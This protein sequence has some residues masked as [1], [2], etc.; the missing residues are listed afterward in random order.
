M[1]RPH[2][3]RFPASALPHIL[4]TLAI[5]LTIALSQTQTQA[6]ERLD[7]PSRPLT[8]SIH[9]WPDQQERDG[10]TCMEA[11]EM[12]EVAY[13]AY[14]EV[15]HQL[16][17]LRMAWADRLYGG[18]NI[19]PVRTKD[20][21]IDWGTEWG[22]GGRLIQDLFWSDIDGCGK[23]L[24]ALKLPEMSGHTTVHL[25][26][27]SSL[28]DFAI[29]GALLEVNGQKLHHIS[30][31]DLQQGVSL[32]LPGQNAAFSVKLLL[33]NLNPQH[34]GEPI[35]AV[36]HYGNWQRWAQTAKG[37]THRIHTHVS[38]RPLTA[39]ERAYNTYVPQLQSIYGRV[40]RKD[41]IHPIAPPSVI[42]HTT[43]TANDKTFHTTSDTDKVDHTL[44][45]IKGVC[46]SG[47]QS[48]YGQGTEAQCIASCTHDIGRIEWLINTHQ[49]APQN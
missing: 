24:R 7:A 44:K 5:G 37:G 6:T 46:T 30:P 18:H 35:T 10:T 36:E 17:A 29:A 40:P 38:T 16:D 9:N 4:M 42:A 3:Q 15:H 14:P 49:E 1:H 12:M 8:S 32:K 22:D 43:I 41:I 11:V 26:M 34:G 21:F 48:G 33:H 28:S 23:D 19:K 2:S 47:C 45:R 13:G 25:K 39:K 31:Q 20:G 27:Q